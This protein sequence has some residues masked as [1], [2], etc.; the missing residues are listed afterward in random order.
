MSAY[1]QLQ[2]TLGSSPKNW[3]V[4]GAAGFIGNTLADRPLHAGHN[5]RWIRYLS[6][7]GIRYL[8]EAK[9]VSPD[10]KNLEKQIEELRLKIA[11]AAK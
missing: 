5:G 2:T 8:E 11:P 6:T 4:T 9:T 1:D 3:L 10:P 7:S